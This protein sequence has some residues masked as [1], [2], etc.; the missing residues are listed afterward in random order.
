M[1]V[2]LVNGSV[3][4]SFSIEGP[5]TGKDY[6]VQGPGGRYGLRQW[7]LV[8]SAPA[9][10]KYRTEVMLGRTSFFVPCK[11]SSLALGAV[12]AT[13]AMLVLAFA[14]RISP[15]TPNFATETAE[16]DKT[17]TEESGKRSAEHRSGNSSAEN[18]TSPTRSHRGQ[19]I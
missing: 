2:L 1:L 14:S 17:D 12:I 9:R 15:K 5:E 11:V 19:A 6:T 18:T 13:V 7:V 10:P 3:G 4:Y 16:P 8:P